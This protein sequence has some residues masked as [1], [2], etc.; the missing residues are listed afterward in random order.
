MYSLIVYCMVYWP[1]KR[2]PTP[3]TEDLGYQ[4]VEI[5][6]SHVHGTSRLYTGD[7]GVGGICKYIMV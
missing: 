1:I 6:P 2:P 3:N 4:P 7:D 5:C